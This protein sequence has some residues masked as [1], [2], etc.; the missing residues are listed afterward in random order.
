MD[1]INIFAGLNLI[2]TFGA[3]ISGAKR[4]FKE[5]LTVH[6]EKPVTYLQKLPLVLSTGSLIGL[7]LG[8]FQIGTLEY[9]PEYENA[10]LIGLVVYISFSW[11]QIW[12][13]KTLGDSYSQ[14]IL[15]L[16]DHKLVNAGPFKIIRHPQYLSQIILDIGAGFATLSYI[17]IIFALIEIPFIIMRAILE[18]KL[19]S[20]H[21]R[22]IYSEYKSKT[23]FMIPFLG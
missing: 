15:I 12:A 8:I 5:K 6:K 19:L 10:R 16:K 1:P 17:V 3:N 11:L 23:G 13:Y 21:F 7:I 4:G 2:A 14:E 22:E 9:K 18:E 20:K